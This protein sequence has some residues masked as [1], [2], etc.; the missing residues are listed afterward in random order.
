VSD[1]CNPTRD[2]LIDLLHARCDE[3]KRMPQIVGNDS[4]A[5]PWD[6]AHAAIDGLLDTIVGR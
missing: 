2:M 1:E 6:R 4:Y 3:A 5:T